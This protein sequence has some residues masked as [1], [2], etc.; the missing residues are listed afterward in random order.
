MAGNRSAIRKNLTQKIALIL[1]AAVWAA[2]AA[3]PFAVVG[4]NAYGDAYAAN[5]AQSYIVLE[6]TTKRVLSDSN[7]DARLP[8][9]ST[10]KVMTALIAI[11]KGNPAD[12]VT[13]PGEAVGIE[14]SSI[15]LKK[16]EKFTLE[17]LLYG[18]M[19][20]SG[21]DA[22][23]AIALLP[24]TRR[25][26]SSEMT[27]PSTENSTCAPAASVMAISSAVNVPSPSSV[28][29]IFTFS[30]STGILTGASISLPVIS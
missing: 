22:A 4:N 23:T 19:L 30:M 11:E 29:V 3:L 15:Y 7:A 21:N 18:L 2:L 14:G 25:S 16:G 13:I 5:G 9:A 10:T 6:K 24:T 12:T 27:L 1:I 28:S 26:P 20:R 17:E 8:M